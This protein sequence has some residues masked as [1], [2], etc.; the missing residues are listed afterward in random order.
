MGLISGC[1]YLKV[2]LKA[3]IYIYVNSTIK[4]CS[5][6]ITKICLI[7]DFFH[8]PPVSTLSC[9]YL[10]EFSKTFETVL[11]GYSGAGG[12]LIHEKYQ[13]QKSRDTVP[14]NKGLKLAHIPY[15][16]ACKLMRIQI[17]FR[18]Q[19]INYDVHPG[20]MR[21]RIRIFT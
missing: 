19:L 8:L 14:L 12:K 6:K 21:I 13:K 7:E 1:R 3:K 20:W 16:L 10:Q 2:N 15:I 4:R 18:I 11:M 17:R 9:E 5:N